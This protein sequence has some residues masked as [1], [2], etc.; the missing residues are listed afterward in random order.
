MVGDPFAQ[1]SVSE[2]HWNPITYEEAL[3]RELTYIGSK[4]LA[5]KSAWKFLST[6]PNVGFSLVSI[7]PGLVFG[8]PLHQPG[9]E[10]D[11]NTSNHVIDGLIRGHYVH[12][13][14]ATD[15]PCW[16][17]VRDVAYAHIKALTVRTAAG[18]RFL[19]CAGTYTYDHVVQIIWDKFPAL[20]VSLPS[21]DDPL[22]PAP[23]PPLH[24]DNKKSVHML[25]VDYRS[26]ED[27]VY[28]TVLSLI[29]GHPV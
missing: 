14:P 8:P 17:D 29:S 19:L 26:L 24:F 2:A 13:V 9:K 28:S 21:V 16:V 7:N 15:V 1:G 12:K 5:E 23:S 18:D 22:K 4:T 20:H 10:Q 27:S 25:G 11:V 3:Q 6:T